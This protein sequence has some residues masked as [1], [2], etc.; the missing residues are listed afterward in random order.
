MGAYAY[1]GDVRG[2]AYL[3]FV[4]TVRLCPD[5][6]GVPVASSGGRSLSQGSNR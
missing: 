2:Q 1:S 3:D 5:I 4:P 6:P